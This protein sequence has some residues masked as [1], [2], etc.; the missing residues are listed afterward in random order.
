[1]LLK[2]LLPGKQVA[3]SISINFTPK[4]RKTK[5]V[6][7]KQKKVLSYLNK[8]WYFPMFSRWNSMG[9]F[10]GL[11]VW[12]TRDQL[13]NA[14]GDGHRPRLGHR[15]TR[16][17]QGTVEQKKGDPE[18]NDPTIQRSKCFGKKWLV[19]KMGWV[20]KTVQNLSRNHPESHYPTN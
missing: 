3:V 1:M 5:P 13:T 19:K 2:F 7:Y 12:K 18:S 4:N 6:A 16:Q 11:R 17:V 20:E 10:H 14:K 8:R 15:G 9:I